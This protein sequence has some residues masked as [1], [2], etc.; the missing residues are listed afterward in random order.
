[1]PAARDQQDVRVVVRPLGCSDVLMI[2]NV[3][4]RGRLQAQVSAVTAWSMHAV[5]ALTSSGSMAGNMPTR[6]WLRPSLR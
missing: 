5:N 4:A 2:M 6:S 3:A 1:M